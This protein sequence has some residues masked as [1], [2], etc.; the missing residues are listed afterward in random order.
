[1]QDLLTLLQNTLMLAVLG[2]A[3]FWVYFQF[4]DR[5]TIEKM[6]RAVFNDLAAGQPDAWREKVLKKGYM[7]RW[8]FRKASMARLQQVKT[9]IDRR[10]KT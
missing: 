2:F 6:G 7:S 5:L 9:E 8:A 10:S 1:M 4:F 3:L